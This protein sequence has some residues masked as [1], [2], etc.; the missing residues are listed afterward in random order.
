MMHIM[1]RLMMERTSLLPMQVLKAISSASTMVSSISGVGGSAR[2]QSATDST[3]STPLL[4]ELIAQGRR[5]QGSLVAHTTLICRGQ[6][7]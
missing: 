2:R 1:L 5:P 7:V 4:D 6:T 3:N